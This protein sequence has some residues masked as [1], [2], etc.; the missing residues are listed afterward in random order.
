M[1]KANALQ[2]FTDKAAEFLAVTVKKVKKTDRRLLIMI[3]AAVLLVI[4][5][6]ALIIHG[7]SSGKDDGDVI[8]AG[9]NYS[10]IQDLPS[11]DASDKAE[12]DNSDTYTVNT[13][14]DADLNM[15]LAADRDSDVVK[16]IPNGTELEVM[17]I[18]DSEADSADGYGWGYVEYNG[19]RG[20]VFME[21]LKK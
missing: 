16:R 10:N 2:N 8:E 14:S 12:A 18:D 13:G 6:F 4:I 9:S 5:I 21:Y 17:F 15:R 3:G 19:E 20:W 7:V 11:E 1:A